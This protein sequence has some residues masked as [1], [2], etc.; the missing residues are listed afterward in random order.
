[1]PAYYGLL[2]KVPE[3]IW[4][5][6]SEDLFFKK[7]FT[8]NNKQLIYEAHTR[9][10]FTSC[11]FCTNLTRSNC[12]AHCLKCGMGSYIHCSPLLPGLMYYDKKNPD[13]SDCLS[14]PWLYKKTCK[15]FNRLD[16]KNYFKNFKVPFSWLTV[17][18]YEILE[19]LVYGLSARERPCHIC[20]TI[21]YTIYKKC[22]DREDFD[23][24]TPCPKISS[25]MESIYR[26]K[27][28][29]S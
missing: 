21:D 19:G 17:Y 12:H 5:F 26:V 7:Q 10:G 23:K 28:D 2:K 9:Q 29:A 4:K 20:A 1:M 15:Y 27:T 18:N 8:R 24:N 14:I 25:L 11:A 3:K 22:V 16:M 13:E 6:L